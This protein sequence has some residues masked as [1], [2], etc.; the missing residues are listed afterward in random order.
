MNNFMHG[1][2]YPLKCVNLFFKYPKLILYSIVPMTINL[3]IYGTIFFFAYNWLIGSSSEVLESKV[4]NN[5]A[6]EILGILLRLFSFF[7]VLLLCYFAFVIFGG[8][9][10]APFN[11]RMSK[12]IEEKEFGI[13][14]DEGLTFF[15]EAFFSIKEESKK[16]LFYLSVMLP[17]FFINFI[18]MIGNTISFVFGSMFSFFYNALD[19][20]DYPMTRKMTGFRNKLRVIISQKSLSAG[21]GA[22]AFILTFIPVINVLINPLLV[23]SGTSLYYNKNYSDLTK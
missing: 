1:F 17:L 16:I 4:N 7:L 8:L 22:I 18:P 3:I 14:I 19:Y 21:F 11:E 5:I 9:V 13:Y 20:M 15:S 2:F 23:V 10:S 6:V 12:L